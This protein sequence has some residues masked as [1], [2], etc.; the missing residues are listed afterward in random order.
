MEGLGL[1]VRVA[2]TLPA[3]RLERAARMRALAPPDVIRLVAQCLPLDAWRAAVVVGGALRDAVRAL[4]AAYAV[5]P[6]FVR[7]G[8]GGDARRGLARDQLQQGRSIRTTQAFPH[9][10]PAEGACD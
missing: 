4:A 8:E 9:F 7:A 1:G 5:H 10:G 6:F 2:P 3:A